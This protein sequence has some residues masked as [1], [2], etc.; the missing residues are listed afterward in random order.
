MPTVSKKQ[1]YIAV[2]AVLFV[3]ALYFVFRNKENSSENESGSL[4]D[5]VNQDSF[6]TST[7]ATTT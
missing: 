5:A 1:I 4:S 7:S 3:V 2:A 6:A